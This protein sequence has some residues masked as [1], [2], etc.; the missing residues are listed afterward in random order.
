MLIFFFIKKKSKS[1]F[2]K[3]MIKTIILLFVFSTLSFAQDNSTTLLKSKPNFILNSKINRKFN[4]YNLKS[5]EIKLLRGIFFIS[6][7]CHLQIKIS[8]SLSTFLTEFCT[9]SFQNPPIF[10]D[11]QSL[12]FRFNSSTPITVILNSSFDITETIFIDS[13]DITFK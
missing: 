13:L 3:K 10:C 4:Y 5:M 12:L 2:F 7:L 11:L 9:N 1:F 8:C 6:L